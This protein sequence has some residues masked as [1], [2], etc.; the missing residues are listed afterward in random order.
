MTARLAARP[1]NDDHYLILR[2]GGQQETLL[3]SLSVRDMP[4]RYEEHGYTMLVADGA[5]TPTAL[6][7][8]ASSSRRARRPG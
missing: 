3:T 1:V 7:C 5:S 4:P 2:L 6:A 8:G